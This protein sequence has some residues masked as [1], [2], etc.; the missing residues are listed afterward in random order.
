VQSLTY[1]SVLYRLQRQTE[2]AEQYALRGLEHAR[3]A[4]LRVYEGVALANLAWIELLRGDIRRSEEL[5]HT[6]LALMQD[7]NPTFPF[8]WLALLPLI[9]VSLETDSLPAAVEYAQC[10]LDPLQQ[11]LSDHLADRLAGALR[12][13][14]ANDFNQAYYVLLQTNALGSTKS[15]D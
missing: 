1:L 8:Q 9:A 3:A 12:D 10:L 14:A 6:G 7:D 2:Q 11:R 4:R 5:G 15:V 13:A